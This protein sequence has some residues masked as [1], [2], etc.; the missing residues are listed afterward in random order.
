MLIGQLIFTYT[1]ALPVPA[2]GEFF[3]LF[4]MYRMKTLQVLAVPSALHFVLSFCTLLSNAHN[5]SFFSWH[6][7]LACLHEIATSRVSFRPGLAS[8]FVHVNFLS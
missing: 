3:G 8:F 7:L 6:S 4:E 1:V 5:G 2:E